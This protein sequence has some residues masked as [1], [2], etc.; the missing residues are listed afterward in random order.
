[1]NKLLI[2]TTNPGKF[3]ELTSLLK[4]LPIKF[5]SLKDLKIKDVIN[6]TGKTF[7]ANAIIKAKYYQ[8]ISGLPT[9]ADDGGLEIDVLNGEPGVNSH[10]W[11]HKN[12]DSTDNELIS[13][14]LKRL[15]KIPI[16]KRQA[17]LRV[18]LALALNQKQ[19]YTAQA[20]I[21]GIIPFQISAN[22][23]PGYPYRSMLFIPE[24]NK[25]YNEHELT[26]SENKQYNHRRKA[27]DKIKPFLIKAMQ[28]RCK[29]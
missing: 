28:I 12:K 26:E 21:R 15:L 14:T 5:I 4:D 24:I 1:M 10:R 2:A 27:L 9:L 3:L 16:E 29:V 22:R 25:F 8:K 18:V 7:A 13:Y 19:I 20:K 6:E 23:M 17:Q 11:V